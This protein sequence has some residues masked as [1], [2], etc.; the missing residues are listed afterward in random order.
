MGGCFAFDPGEAGKSL[1]A[2]ANP[3]A[4]SGSLGTQGALVIKSIVNTRYSVERCDV[5]GVLCSAPSLL[6]IKVMV[7][8]RLDG[9][10]AA[11]KNISVTITIIHRYE[12][13][14]THHPLFSPVACED[15][16]PIHQPGHLTVLRAQ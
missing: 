6:S 13:L 7:A 8:L 16:E 2:N 1:L 10:S 5:H 11:E 15:T 3:S 4:A 9:T 12:V 14:I